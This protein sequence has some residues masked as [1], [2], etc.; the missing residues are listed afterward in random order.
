MM[1]RADALVAVEPHGAL[2]RRGIGVDADHL[3]RDE[4]FSAEA[5]RLLQRARPELVA[6]DARREPE[7]ILDARRGAG[8]AAR[9]FALD[10]DRA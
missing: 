10:Q 7:I 9:R 1:L 8:L 3:S 5:L 6:R 4:N 2:L